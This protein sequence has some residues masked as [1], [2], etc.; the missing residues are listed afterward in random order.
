MKTIEILSKI[1]SFFLN[2]TSETSSNEIDLMTINE[3]FSKG[4]AVGNLSE[5]TYYTCMKMLSESMGKISLKLFAETEK[6]VIRKSNQAHN[7]IKLR[8]NPYMTAATFWSTV[9]FLRNHYG[10]AYVWC[11]YHRGKLLDLWILKNQDVK[12]L[13][14]NV[15]LFGKESALY[16]HYHDTASNTYYTFDAR[17]IMHFKSGVSYDGITGLSV[18][19]ILQENMDGNKASQS[20]MNKLYK[21]GLT[22][23]A[24]LEYTGDLDDNAKKRL[25]AGFE[26]FANGEA[27]TGK[28]IPVPLGMKLTPL[29]IKLTDSQFFELKKYSSL[30]IA[31]AFGIKPNHL[32]NYEKSSYS[33]SEMQNLSFYTDTLLFILTQYEQELTF[34]LLTTKERDEGFY[35][36]FNISAILRADTKTQMETLVSGVNNGVYLINEAR[37]YLDLHDLEEGDSPIVN[38]NYIP[39][40]KV[41]SQYRGGENE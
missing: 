16:Y 27:N 22:A 10:N 28:I 35:F 13:M 24:V 2:E 29:N 17:E 4:K 39:L 38:G 21:S 7:L 9:E 19:E 3:F 11:R 15:G 33:N 41:G 31:S 36:K 18:Q 34:K 6:G 26:A 20:F 32:N 14:D 25:V 23:K 5:I 30:Q 40:S 8:P 1:K 37:R 12:V